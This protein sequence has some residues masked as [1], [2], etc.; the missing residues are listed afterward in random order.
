MSNHLIICE[1]SGGFRKSTHQPRDPIRQI[2]SRKVKTILLNCEI[3]KG[4]KPRTP[5]F[6][7]TETL[8]YIR[9]RWLVFAAGT[10]WPL[11][12][13]RQRLTISWIRPV[14][15]NS[16]TS[17]TPWAP[18]CSSQACL[19]APSTITRYRPW[20][21]SRRWRRSRARRTLPSTSCT[22]PWNSCWR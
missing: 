4:R 19:S 2:Q 6:T 8:M 7:N 20:L 16:T 17:A 11:S 22:R 9:H 10:R 18:P 21:P 5:M 14:T 15:A 12:M 13:F 1:I 3:T